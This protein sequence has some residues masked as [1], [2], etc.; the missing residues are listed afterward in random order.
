MRIC[1]VVQV[2]QKISKLHW[3]VITWKVLW[4][5]MKVF[6]MRQ[7]PSDYWSRII[8]VSDVNSSVQY[9][10]MIHDYLEQNSKSEQLKIFAVSGLNNFRW[11][12]RNDFS[13]RLGAGWIQWTFS[14]FWH[15]FMP[16][17][18]ISWF[19]NIFSWSFL[20]PHTRKTRQKPWFFR[21]C[22]IPK[23]VSSD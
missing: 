9:V 17:L 11:Y 16:Y 2:A 7:P 14:N 5:S 6:Y 10:L 3:M 21:H 1:A 8:F 15:T 20:R 13:R 12:R 23:T 22:Y 4:Q 19:Q 18:E